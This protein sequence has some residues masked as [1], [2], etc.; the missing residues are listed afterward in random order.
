MKN[1]KIFLAAD[2]AG[3][4]AKNLLVAYLK[5]QGHEVVDLG[6]DSADS[7]DYPDYATKLAKIMENEADTF[8]ILVCGSGIGMSIAANRFKH[9]RAAMVSEPVSASLTRKHN[10]ANVVCLSSRLIGIDMQKACV[11]TFLTTPFEGGRHQRRVEKI[12]QLD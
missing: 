3:F 9:I 1:K 4:E 10:D 8:G 7:V 5:E 2:H 11:D 6:T 12:N